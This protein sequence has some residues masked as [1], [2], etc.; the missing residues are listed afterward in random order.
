MNGEVIGINS[1]IFSRSGGYMGLAFAIPID[2][3][4][5]VRGSRSS[6]TARCSTAAGRDDPGRQSGARRELRTEEAA[7][8]RWSRR[9]PKDGAG[10]KAGLEPGDVILKFDGKAIG[11]SAAT[12]AV[13]AAVKPG[14]R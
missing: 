3:A 1:Q 14:S 2:V 5:N 11:R 12:A 10:A 13:V 6:N 7:K 9:C 8:A 4:M